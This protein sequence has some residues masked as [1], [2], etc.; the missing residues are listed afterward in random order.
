MKRIGVILC[1]LWA[2]AAGAQGGNAPLFITD[3]QV[4]DNG[5]LLMTCKGDKTLRLYDEAGLKMLKSWK[6]AESR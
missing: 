3:I 2:L 1:M 4:M 6:R 5:E